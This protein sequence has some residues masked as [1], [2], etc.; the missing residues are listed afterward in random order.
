MSLSDAPASGLR[1]VTPFPTAADRHAAGFGHDDLRA[2]FLRAGREAVDDRELLQLLLAGSHS[3]AEAERLAG[4]LLDTF[5]TP[6]RVLAARTDT[7]RTIPGLD[8]A[9]IA[10]VKIAEALGI[11]MARAALPETF[12]PQLATYDKVVEYCRALAAHRDV[13][14]FRALYLDTKNRL[15]RDE[16]LQ[17]GTVNHTP[18]YPRQVCVRALEV[19][20]TA[21]VVVHPHPSGDPTPSRA[22]VEMTNRLRDALKTIDV[23]LHDHIVVTPCDAFSF[24]QKGLL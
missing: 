24:K 19:G 16:L 15:I 21:L 2:R 20:A 1:D 4:V 9:G 8:D 5:C 10:A 7:L 18:V 22:D 14:E 12:H 11:A 3:A 13:E 17:T 6:S 23:D